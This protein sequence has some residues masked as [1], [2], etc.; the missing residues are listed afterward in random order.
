[1]M[2]AKHGTYLALALVASFGSLSQARADGAF[3]LSGNVPIIDIMDVA[4]A[5]PNF[6]LGNGNGAANIYR[7]IAAMTLYSNNPDGFSITASGTAAGLLT[8]TVTSNTI[9][10]TVALHTTLAGASTAAGSLLPLGAGAGAVAASYVSPIVA[11]NEA[12]NSGAL[13]AVYDRSTQ[14]TLVYLGAKVA[15][16]SVSALMGDTY[17]DTLTL[18]IVSN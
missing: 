1:M 10:Y 15:G 7:A 16:A 17:T 11:G 13:T 4:W 18:A 6:G 12:F 8:G 5:N 3:S 9:A 14:A 2:L